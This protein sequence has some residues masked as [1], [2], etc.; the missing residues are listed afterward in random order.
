MKMLEEWELLEELYWKQKAQIEWLQEGDKNTIFFFNSMKARCQDNPI[1]G[2]V[3][4]RG[5]RLSSF[6]EISSEAVQYFESLFRE[7]SQGGSPE[8]EK[9]IS[10]IPSLVSKD[11]S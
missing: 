7:D 8:E 3:N 4:D 10:C 1:T 2:L 5:D 11:M 6:P 9:I